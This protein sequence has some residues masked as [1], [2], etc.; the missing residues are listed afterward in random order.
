MT[1]FTNK[2]S[3]RKKHFWRLDSKCITMFMVRGLINFICSQSMHI[4]HSLAL[5]YTAPLSQAETG[6]AYHREVPLSEVLAVD[7]G[8]AGLVGGAEEGSNFSFALR[9]V[10]SLLYRLCA[11]THNICTGPLT[12]TTSWWSRPPRTRTRGSPPWTLTAC[13]TGRPPSASRS[14][15]PTTPTPAQQQVLSRTR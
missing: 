8:R 14:C 2:E 13:S 12:P 9:C 5:H 1:H 4:T 6:S 7:E 11:H 15:R 3:T 10:S